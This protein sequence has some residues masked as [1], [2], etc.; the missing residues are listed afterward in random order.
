MCGNL[1]RHT[2][3]K[4]KL[5]IPHFPNVFPSGYILDVGCNW[6]RW[7]IAG[8]LAGYRVVGIDIHLRSLL[9]ARALAE[10]LV[11]HNPPLFVLADAR[12]MPFRAGCFSG[13]FSYSVIQHFS[14]ANTARILAEIGRVLRES[15][16]GYIQM[17]NSAGVRSFLASLSTGDAEGNEFDVRRYKIRELLEM[18]E[19]AIGESDWE[20]DCFFGL[21]VHA[22][23]RELIALP[24]RWIIDAS[25]LI[26]ATSR[27]IPG[28][29]KFADSVFVKSVKNMARQSPIGARSTN[30]S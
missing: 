11:P 30:A 13:A 4:D 19:L 25:E 23:D 14:K 22:A 15:G 10:R 17:P 1:F 9:V 12:Q 6:G 26:L 21:N 7:S 8:A 5:P 28:L 27:K 20:P 18:F 29:K 3:L 16:V 2:V 24:Q